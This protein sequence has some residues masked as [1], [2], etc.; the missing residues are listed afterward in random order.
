MNFSEKIKKLDEIVNKMEN[1]D[2]D[3]DESLKLYKKGSNLCDELLKE[4]EIVIKNIEEDVN[5]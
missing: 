1:K 5:E 3:L 4:I 2:L